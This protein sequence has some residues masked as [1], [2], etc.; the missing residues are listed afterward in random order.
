MIQSISINSGAG[1]TALSANHSFKLGGIHT[2]ISGNVPIRCQY[3]LCGGAIG[4]GILPFWSCM[5]VGKWLKYN[6]SSMYLM[7]P[8]VS[9]DIDMDSQTNISYMYKSRYIDIDIDIDI[10]IGIYESKDRQTEI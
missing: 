1:E 9:P 6:I 4:M 10:D 2:E 5:S 7:I 8:R 3:S